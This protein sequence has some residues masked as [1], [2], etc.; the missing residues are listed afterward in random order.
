MISAEAAMPADTL[1]EEDIVAWAEEQAE[2]IRNIA[3]TRPELSNVLDWTN[4]AEELD[5]LGRTETRSCTGPLKQFLVHLAKR[6]SSANPLV[7]EHWRREM[8]LFQD[9]ARDAFLPSMRRK[10]DIDA[11][12]QN[13]LRR[14]KPML[15]EYDESLAPD[16]PEKCPLT[17]DEVLAAD[18]DVDR[19]IVIIALRLG[20]AIEPLKTLA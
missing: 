8:A 19:A 9:E 11:I 7:L 1:Y 5:C 2:A 10:I 13:A 6:L 18:F 3:R 15:G 17:L 12:W 20:R 14:T 16:L 4:L